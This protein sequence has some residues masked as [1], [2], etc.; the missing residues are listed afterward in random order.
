MERNDFQRLAI[1]S[2]IKESQ[3]KIM[4]KDQRNNYKQQLD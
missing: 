3:D 2:K 1:E 4:I